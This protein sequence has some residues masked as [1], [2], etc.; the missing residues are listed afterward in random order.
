MSLFQKRWAGIAGLILIGKKQR[1]HVI[2][3]EK[4][5]RYCW[6]EANNIR[7]IQP[8]HPTIYLH[9]RLNAR[10]HY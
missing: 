4:V 2:F 1:E 5:G 9:Q 8:A 7:L 10:W 6:T 3:A